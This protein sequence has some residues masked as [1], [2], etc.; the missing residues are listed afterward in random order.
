MTETPVLFGPES[1]LV[2]VVCQPTSHEVVGDMACLTFNAGVVPRIGPH[3]F[4]VKLSRVLAAEGVPSMRFD[5]GGLGDSRPTSVQQDFLQQAIADIRAAM[6]YLEQHHGIH[7]FIL[8]GNCSGAIHVYWTALADQRVAGI[9]M[10]DGFWYR[11]RWST[12]VRHWKRF[13]AGSWKA[14][15]VAIGRRIS[16]LWR[17]ANR[18]DASAQ[19]GIFSSDESTA[20]PPRADY[21]R[22]MQTLVD[23]QVNV[24]LVFSGGVIDAYSYARQFRDGFGREPFFAK[25]RCDFLPEIDHTLLSLESQKLLINVI[26][27]WILGIVATPIRPIKDA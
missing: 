3:R 23:R 9:L 14:A 13:R 15:A 10:F 12:P 1:S 26:R 27:T 22:V 4:N 16:G 18:A 11:T 2:G 20:N 21:C 24:F 19:A 17:L 6:D 5:L 25:V 7:R 8:I